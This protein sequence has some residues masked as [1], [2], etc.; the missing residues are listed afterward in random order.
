MS[1]TRE[2]DQTWLVNHLQDDDH[3]GFGGG[4]NMKCKSIINCKMFMCEKKRGRERERD[5]NTLMFLR[6]R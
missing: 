2:R 6:N 4:I 3:N 5:L 1:Y